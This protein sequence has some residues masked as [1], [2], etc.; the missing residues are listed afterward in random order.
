[1]SVGYMTVKSNIDSRAGALAVELRDKLVEVRNFKYWLD[2]A[3]DADLQG[4]GYDATDI[5]RLRSAFADLD[6]VAPHLPRRRG[7]GDAVRLPYLRQVSYR[8][9]VSGG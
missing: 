7:S 8:G 3:V 2:A 4:Y 6:K 1:M 9:C 5:S